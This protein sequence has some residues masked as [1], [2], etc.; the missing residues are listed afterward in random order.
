MNRKHILVVRPKYALWLI[1]A[2]LGST[3]Y[4]TDPQARSAPT[5]RADRLNGTGF[6]SIH[7][8]NVPV[9][10]PVSSTTAARAPDGV[11]VVSTNL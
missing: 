11:L 6:L 9:G 7:E 2:L 8:A 4:V 5:G 3:W 10:T 1:V